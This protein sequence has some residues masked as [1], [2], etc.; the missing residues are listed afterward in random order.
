MTL[1]RDAI[2]G[3]EDEQDSLL[4]QLDAMD[5]Q[6]G[7]MRLQVRAMRAALKEQAGQFVACLHPTSDRRLLPGTM[8]SKRQ[9]ECA[10]CN[11]VI[12][13]E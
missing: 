13:E 9:W 4:A 3:A 10:S 2:L 12:T 5:A 11:A 6:L 7:V 8:G 1:D